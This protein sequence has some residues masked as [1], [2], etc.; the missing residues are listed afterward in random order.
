M[1][2]QQL[3]AEHF[4]GVVCVPPLARNRDQTRTLNLEENDKVVAHIASGGVTR[5]LYGGNALLYHVSTRDFDQMVEWLSG[6]I[7]KY[8]MIPS[9][10]PSFGRATEQA[11]RLRNTNFACAM[12][13]PSA[14]PRTAAGLEIGY[15]E[16]ADILGK[17]LL[18]YVKEEA[19]FGTD[20][21]KGLDAI[22]RLIDSGVGV[23]VKYAVVRKDP[24]EDSYLSEL[25][26][27]VPARCIISGIGERPAIVHMQ[28]WKLPAFT[29]GSVCIAPR[30]SQRIFEHCVKGEFAEAAKLR[31]NFIA[32][33]DLRD[34]WGPAPVLHTAM[35][36]AGIAKTGPVLPYLGELSEQRRSELTPIAKALLLANG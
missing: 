11:D 2:T 26:K 12:M 29:S 19:N 5:F 16:V 13:L 25:L 1:T 36:L 21:E 30:L 32:H 6:Y 4:H 31:A 27:R 15:R 24:R 3:T 22:G 18:L 20:K 17:P 34:A 9:I 10:G 14:D 7:D 33:E 28:D 23:A 8:F 35:E